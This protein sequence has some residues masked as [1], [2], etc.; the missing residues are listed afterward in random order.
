V[1]RERRAAGARLDGAVWVLRDLWGRRRKVAQDA[2]ISGSLAMSGSRSYELGSGGETIE[3]V[4][5]EAVG[6]NEGG[7]A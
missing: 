2:L 1:P 4:G 7:V 5:I 3:L 6:D